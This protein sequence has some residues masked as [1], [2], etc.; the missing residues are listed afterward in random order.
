MS[1][2]SKPIIGIIAGAGP[3][4]GI[5][6]LQKIHDQ[7]IASRDQDHLTIIGWFQPNAIPDRTAFLLGQA[8]ENPGEAIAGQALALAQAGAAVA[9]I[10][11]NTAHASKI[12][13]RVEERLANAG[14]PLIFLHLIRETGCFLQAHFPGAK[15]VGLLATAGTYQ[16]GFYPALLGAFGVEVIVPQDEAVRRGIQAA[17]ADTRFGIKATGSGT[18]QARGWLDAGI[19]ALQHQGAEAII[20]GCTEIPIMIQEREIAGMPIIDPTLILARALIR[21]AAPQQLKPYPASSR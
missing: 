17:I 16:A 18:P 15:R 2:S 6:L 19:T 5:D 10:P 13:K 7:T 20:L 12:F 14:N 4:A 3:Y 1:H 11:C 21:E 8:A 9:A